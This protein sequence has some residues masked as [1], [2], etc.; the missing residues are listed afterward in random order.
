MRHSA[1]PDEQP[2]A[3][4]STPDRILGRRIRVPQFGDTLSRIDWLQE[5]V[6]GHVQPLRVAPS[7]MMW[8][9]EEAGPKGLAINYR[10]SLWASAYTGAAQPVVLSGP[11]LLTGTDQQGHPAGLDRDVVL[12]LFRY[13]RCAPRRGELTLLHTA[14]PPHPAL[15]A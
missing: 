13:A 9:D 8:V 11:V 15:M 7:L 6:G 10:A 2:T 5:Q 14:I 3:V 1:L 4:L 12:A